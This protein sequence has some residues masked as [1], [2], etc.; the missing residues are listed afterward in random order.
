M[1]ILFS[2]SRATIL[3]VMSGL[4]IGMTVAVLFVEEMANYPL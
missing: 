3:L 4:S 1:L 2:L